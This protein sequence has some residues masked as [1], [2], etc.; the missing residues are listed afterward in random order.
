MSNSSRRGIPAHVV[1]P[2]C[3]FPARDSLKNPVHPDI[4]ELSRLLGELAA[5]EDIKKGR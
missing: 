5:L 3:P 4:L 2:K 1:V